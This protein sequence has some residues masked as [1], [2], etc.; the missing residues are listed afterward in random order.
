MGQFFSLAVKLVSILRIA[1][2]TG[3]GLFLKFTD[4][5]VYL[6]A[7]N[8]SNFT[9]ATLVLAPNFATGVRTAKANDVTVTAGTQLKYKVEFANQAVNSK[10]VR[11]SGISIQY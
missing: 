10:E 7:N 9:Q 6:S 2:S 8:G 11:V 4:L 1:S 3:G 5:K